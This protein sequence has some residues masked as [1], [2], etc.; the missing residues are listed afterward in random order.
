M[1]GDRQGIVDY[2]EYGEVRWD[3]PIVTS[4][5][6]TLRA[7]IFKPLGDEPVPVILSYGPYAKGLS[8]E[9][10]YPDQWRIL[11]TGH[12][13]VLLGSSSRYQAW[14]VADPE[15]WVP[16]GYAC[17]R[18]DSRG[19]GSSEGHLDPLS[20]RETQDLYECIE[21]A[22]TQAWSTGKVG[23][24]G[25]SYF[26]INQW[27]VA[28]LKPPHLSA[29][30]VWE[31]AADWYR[32]MTHHGGI[33]STFWDN[34]FDK[35]VAVVQNGLGSRAAVNPNTGVG[36]AGIETLSDE[37]L[38]ARRADFGDDILAHPLDDEY[39][40]ARSAN[41]DEVEVPLLSA[42]N[43]G[44]QGLHTRGNFEA[45]MRAAS[46]QKWLEVHGLEHWTHF[47][48][49][50]GVELQ[51]RF[52]GYF[53]KGEDNGWQEQPPVQL[54]VRHADGNFS[55]RFEDSWPIPDTEWTRLYFDF[56]QGE[57][58]ATEPGQGS[59]REVDPL[60]DGV[61]LLSQ[62]FAEEIEIT[63]P[64][65]A[66]VP[67]S[68]SG[69][70]ADLFLIVRL[71]D[72]AGKEVTFPG[73]L[74]PRTPVAQGWL[75][76]SHRKLDSELSRPYRPY[77]THDTVQLLTPS[78]LYD[79]DI[80]IWPTCVVIP[81]GY[82]LGLTLRGSDFEHKEGSA[83]LTTF[84]NAMTGCGPFLHNDPRDRNPKLVGEPMTFHSSSDRP[85]FILLPVIPARSGSVQY[86]HSELR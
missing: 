76:A 73:A 18:I 19:A 33:L 15:R 54:Q 82:R 3:V 6:V 51:Q 79:L 61:T 60:S 4:D 23:L 9:E 36:V 80:E 1:T 38:A 81:A 48:T 34:W 62:P 26:G 32:D 57:L 14:E 13:E 17:V 72:T 30:C 44:G 86:Q 25:V 65:A 22:G 42:G 74:D 71:F 35:Q 10:G 66:R 39:H 63:G 40:A 37:A 78:E 47:Y 55:Q 46:T 49:D 85:G 21:W 11:T 68:S 16:A 31:G 64:I 24:L 43:W 59:S 83:T 69:R 5:G 77:H 70:D 52:M 84:K 7:D 50:Y 56:D 20:P 75:R 2:A 45:F 41:W 67:L 28:G 27:M 53:L 29:I 12:P 58:S 8:F